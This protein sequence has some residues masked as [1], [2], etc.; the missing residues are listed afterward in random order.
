M[1]T[2]FGILLLVLVLSIV[3]VVVLRPAPTVCAYPPGRLGAVQN[4]YY[5]L[6]DGRNVPAACTGDGWLAQAR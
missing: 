5:T 4:D 3:G 2:T 6:A 1:R